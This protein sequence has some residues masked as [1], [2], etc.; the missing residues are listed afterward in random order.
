MPDR[1]IFREVLRVNL[2]LALILVVQ[3][4]D[5]TTLVVVG[6]MA[7]QDDEV[8]AAIA[9]PQVRKRRLEKRC[10]R[11]REMTIAPTPFLKSI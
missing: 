1:E 8:D 2:S 6:M 10:R 5:V 11:S 3:V 7:C 4:L 9:T